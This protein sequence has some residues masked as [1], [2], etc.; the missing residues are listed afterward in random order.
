MLFLQMVS[1]SYKSIGDHTAQEQTTPAGLKP[2]TTSSQPTTVKML[3]QTLSVAVLVMSVS[4]QSTLTESATS[5]LGSRT[6]ARATTTA[7]GEVQTTITGLIGSLTSGF[8]A[9]VVNA[10]ACDTTLAMQC[11]GDSYACSI[12]SDV[13]IMVTQNPSEYEFAYTTSTLGGQ[14]TLSESCALKGPSG[15]ASQL[16]CHASYRVSAGGQQTGSSTV[17]TLTN[18]DD[19][20]YGQIPITAG[21]EK[22]PSAGSSCTV[23]NQEAAATAVTGVSDVY[24]ILVPVAAG[25]VGAMI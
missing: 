22:L 19:F 13:E 18:S 8:A 9:S 24:K 20:N 1:R 7:D 25:L 17:Q 14:V 15:S 12:A 6:T 21:A 3:A 16:I 2:L 5:S 10:N 23:T 4:A 11:T